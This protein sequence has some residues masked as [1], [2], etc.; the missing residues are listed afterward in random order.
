MAIAKFWADILLDAEYS[1]IPRKNLTRYLR[2]TKYSLGSLR[3]TLRKAS[4]RVSVSFALINQNEEDADEN[5][6]DK[7]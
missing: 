2:L 1:V 3:Q 5:E 7:P 4:S 6:V